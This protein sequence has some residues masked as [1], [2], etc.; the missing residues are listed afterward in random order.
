MSST[1]LG[2]GLAAASTQ[3]RRVAGLN[4]D[5][6]LRHL[7]AGALLQNSIAGGEVDLRQSQQRDDALEPQ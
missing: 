4:V 3:V 2:L 6:V 1:Y 7:I 5:I